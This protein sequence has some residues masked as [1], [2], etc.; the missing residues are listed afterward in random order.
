MTD[1]L[2]NGNLNEKDMRP[3]YLEAERVYREQAQRLWASN[4]KTKREARAKVDLSPEER[5]D[6]Y[7]QRYQEL[8]S[9]PFNRLA[10][11]FIES[12]MAPRGADERRLTQGV[13]EK[14]SD[15]L[16]A[17]SGKTDEELPALMKTA[18]RTGQAD[19]VRAIAQVSLDRNQF[20]VFN[21]WAA[22]EPDLAAALKR[23][24]S[25][26][27][28]EQLATRAGAMRPPK[29]DPEALEPRQEDHDR[30]ASRPAAEAASRAAFYGR[31][32]SIVGAKTTYLPNRG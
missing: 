30:A 16:I 3:E 27:D 8:I 29:A 7:R 23:V 12:V 18:Q 31:P 4:E 21:E 1:Y 32:R 10:G 17:L 22:G 19:L 25:T 2:R 20:G 26:P 9:S 24:R 5:L 11:S 28:P 15:H 13:G 14:F 6:F